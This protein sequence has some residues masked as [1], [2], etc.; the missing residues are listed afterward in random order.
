MPMDESL[1]INIDA[2]D[3]TVDFD[4]D[5][6]VVAKRAKHKKR[7]SKATPIL[8]FLSTQPF[9]SPFD[10]NMAVDA[11]FTVVIPHTNVALENTRGLVQDAIFSRPPEFGSRTAV[12][13]GG[14][15]ALL[16]LDMLSTAKSALVPPFKLSALADPGGSFTTAAAMVACVEDVYK[17]KTSKSLKGASVAV[18]G[19]TGVVGFAAAVIAALQGAKVE[20]V[21]HMGL[22]PLRPLVR[23]AKDRF[24]VTLVPV[25]GGREGD[26]SKIVARAD[27]VLC[28]AAA[29][30]RVLTS[31]QLRASKRL[32]VVADVNAVP[33]S[34]IEGV[35]L[36][37]F[38][39]QLENSTIA[40]VGPLA[41]GDIKYKTQAALLRRMIDAELPLMLDFTHAFDVARGLVFQKSR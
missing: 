39:R 32:K 7:A 17:K 25:L 41:I 8:H 33:P 37:D 5:N 23:A 10:V 15:D 31:K 9:A 2:E 18:F 12:F 30:V 20:V 14:K 27:I 4:G 35:D 34:G 19:A 3:G 26:K 13:I 28:A 38:G 22:A 36:F 11:G 29:G 40:S 6:I 16:A 1:R 21:S 24:G